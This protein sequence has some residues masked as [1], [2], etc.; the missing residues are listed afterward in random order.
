MEPETISQE[1]NSTADSISGQ[2]SALPPALEIIGASLKEKVRIYISRAAEIEQHLRAKPGEWGK[3]QAEFN[4]AINN[5]FREIMEFERINLLAGRPD[6]VLKLKKLFVN[7]LREIF[8]KG[9]YNLWSF[10][11]PYGYA[12]D[13]KIIEDIY[14][15]SPTSF[16]F[17]RL[18]DNYFQMSAI[19]VA[20]RNRK[21]D[22][23][24]LV[25]NF[26]NERKHEPLRI[27][28]L[29]AG[30]C[31]DI[32]E[33]LTGGE[34]KNQRVVFDVSDN[35]RKALEY[36]KELLA[37]FPNI[38][39]FCENAFKIRLSRAVKFFT[40]RRYDF[41]Y[42]AGL[43]D[44]L[45][46]KASVRMVKNLKEFLKPGAGLAIATVRDKYSNPSVHYM[47]WVGDWNLVYRTDEEFQSIFIDA[48]IKAEKLGFQYEQ[49]GI[50]VYV[51]IK[52]HRNDQ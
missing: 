1:V 19:S 48:G 11:K 44:Y 18:F 29:A 40:D 38:N 26:C 27:L 35:E 12:G 30:S 33:I 15:N 42:A 28:S 22:F 8:L 36:G 16:G 4:A 7:R 31:R 2:P 10:K 32:K 39:Y 9:P 21:E 6:R 13:F 43:F 3:F 24:R 5:I 37:G 25:V 34:L 20:V 52:D 51:I 17:E 23:K 45:T 14:Q 41:V 49:Q 50:M 46:H 47:E